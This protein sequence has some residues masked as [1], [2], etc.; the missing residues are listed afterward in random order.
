[1]K[2]NIVFNENRTALVISDNLADAVNLIHKDTEEGNDI[3]AFDTS[4][5][6]A[7]AYRVVRNGYTIIEEQVPIMRFRN[8]QFYGNAHDIYMSIINS[9]TK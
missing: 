2:R 3:F 4:L 9:F 5:H 1:M 7:Y 8:F 6:I